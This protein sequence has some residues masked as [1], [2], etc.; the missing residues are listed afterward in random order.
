MKKGSFV[1]FIFLLSLFLI[2]SVVLYGQDEEKSREPVD[3]KIGFIFNILGPLPNIAESD[4]GI[5]SGLGIKYWLNRKMALRGLFDLYYVND[6]TLS[7]SELTVGVAASLEYHFT[8][9][10][11]SPYAGATVGTR[12]KTGSVNN[13][14]LYFGGL[15]GVEVKLLDYLSLYGEYSLL[16]AMDEP[17]L[18]I[19]L[20]IGNNSQ[21]GLV[22][23]LP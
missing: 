11:V 14:V 10:K 19:D 17:I 7:T 23:Y 20:G 4:D 6:S 5:Q 13:L 12:I 16:A 18:E 3:R 9:G 15:L 1:Y 2:F 21:I 8:E 22:I